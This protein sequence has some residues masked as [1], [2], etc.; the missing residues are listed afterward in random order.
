MSRSPLHSRLL[1]GA[2]LG[3]LGVSCTP[4]EEPFPNEAELE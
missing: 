1:A 2:L 3:A 4:P